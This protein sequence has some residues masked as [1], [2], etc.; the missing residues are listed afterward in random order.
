MSDHP[1]S[2]EE[3]DEALIRF[4]QVFGQWIPHNRALQLEL[5]GHEPG[6]AIIRLP[7]ALQLVGNP[8]TGVLHGGAIT[9]LMDATCGASV[10][11]KRRKAGRI[12]TL[13]L[14]IDYLK[15]ASPPLDVIARAECYK[16]TRSIAFV[17][18]VAHH[19]DLRDPIAHAAGTFMLFDDD[20]GP[21]SST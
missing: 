3:P 16:V 15:P 21:R 1:P 14:R 11:I 7:Y 12:A 4:Q 18:C 2:P 6:V 17:N 10:F 19:G 9:S 13:D 8:E 5:I 20:F